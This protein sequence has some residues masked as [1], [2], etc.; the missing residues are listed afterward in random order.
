[1][2]TVRVEAVEPSPKFQDQLEMLPLDVSVR[3]TTSGANP[4]VGLAVKLATGAG[5]GTTAL[6][7]F[8]KPLVVA[9][10]YALTAK[11]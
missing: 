8:D 1:L 11:K 2:A 7:S 5:T 3:V 6:T 4:V 10:S 9:L